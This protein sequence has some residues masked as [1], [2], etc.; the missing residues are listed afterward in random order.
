MLEELFDE[1]KKGES[2]FLK[3]IREIN[4]SFFTHVNLPVY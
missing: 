2:Y 1:K 4:K 3:F